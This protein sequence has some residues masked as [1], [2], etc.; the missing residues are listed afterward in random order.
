MSGNAFPAIGFLFV[1]FSVIVL[2]YCMQAGKMVYS[3]AIPIFPLVA[4]FMFTVIIKNPFYGILVFYLARHLL[5]IGLFKYGSMLQSSYTLILALIF[6]SVYYKNRIKREPFSGPMTQELSISFKVV[7]F[8]MVSAVFISSLPRVLD[9]EMF[10]NPKVMSGFGRVQREPYFFFFNGILISILVVWL[11]NSERKL[12]IFFW[13]L[14]VI[15][16]CLAVQGFLQYYGLVLITPNQELFYFYERR[17]TAATGHSAGATAERIMPALCLVLSFLLVE[18]GKKVLTA[19]LISAFLITA[20]L[21]TYT[22][23]VYVGVACALIVFCL[24]SIS[25]DMLAQRKTRILLLCLAVFLAIVI[26]VEQF[27]LI[28]HFTS[29]ARTHNHPYGGS[30][31]RLRIGRWVLLVEPFFEN[32]IF[33]YGLGSSKEILGVYAV[34]VYSR[35][36]SSVHSFYVSWLIDNGVIGFFAITVLYIASIK[37]LMKA[38]SISKRGHNLRLFIYANIILSTF[39]GVSVQ[40]LA[41]SEYG[42][43]I[44]MFLYFS[45]S[46]VALRLSRTE[47][48]KA[49]RETLPA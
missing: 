22:R 7:L 24:L 34:G 42:L 8:I 48:N 15:G 31:L 41:N 10:F 43:D 47:R 3:V 17:L 13:T 38:R 29:S 6:F 37:N 45:L 46:H 1:I 5:P 28:D 30:S 44:W 40:Y 25:R 2:I 39:C 11:V 12:T 49:I 32:P 36:Y 18:K 26:A 27:G 23:A 33:G 21:L 35:L 9:Y 14:I 20:I 16:I 4:F 19:F